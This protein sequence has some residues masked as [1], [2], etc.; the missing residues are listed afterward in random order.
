LFAVLPGCESWLTRAKS[1]LSECELFLN[2]THASGVPGSPATES[3]REACV[4]CPQI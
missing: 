1:E 3:T 4:P 2:G